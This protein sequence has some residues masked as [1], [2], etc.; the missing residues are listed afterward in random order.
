MKIAFRAFVWTLFC[1]ATV[2]L[3]VGI[4]LGRST[5]TG[6][7]IAFTISEGNQFTIKAQSATIE[8]NS[9]EFFFLNQPVS[10]D[11]ITGLPAMKPYLGYNKPMYFKAD[12][13]T[14]EGDSLWIVENGRDVTVHV[15]GPT[16]MTVQEDLVPS[17]RFL[18]NTVWIVVGALVWLYSLAAAMS[19]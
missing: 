6:T 14:F 2:G 10:G 4:N 13:N 17:R 19:K 5:Y 8:G 1:V 16:T 18:L 11:T 15:T 3:L 9:S 12:A 7:D